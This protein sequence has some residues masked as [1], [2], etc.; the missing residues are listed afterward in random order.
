METKVD[1]EVSNADKAI[2]KTLNSEEIKTME[3]YSK[4]SPTSVTLSHFLDHS[5]GGG[6]VEDSFL[7][8]RREIPVRLANMMMEL[9]VMRKCVSIAFLTLSWPS[10]SGLSVSHLGTAFPA[11]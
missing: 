11:A 6:S 2:A 8:L 3:F 9:E 7:F 10:S 5:S 1:I 4:F